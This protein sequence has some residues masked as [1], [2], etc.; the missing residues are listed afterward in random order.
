MTRKCRLTGSHLELTVEGRKLAYTVHFTAYKAATGRGRSHVTG[1]DIMWLQVTGS[2]Q[3]V[4]SFT[5]SHLEVAVE[6][7][8][9]AYTVHF[10]S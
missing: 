3:E 4:T 8:I 5:G 7:R 2:A 6:G 1:N 10:T 9:L